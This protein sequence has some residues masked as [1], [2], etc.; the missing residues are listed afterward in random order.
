M[1]N[2]RWVCG[3]CNAD[4]EASGTGHKA[5]MDHAMESHPGVRGAIK[6][7]VDLETDEIVVPGSGPAVL[8]K[9]Q[10]LGYA[11]KKEE[12]DPARTDPTAPGA[13]PKPGKKTDPIRARAMYREVYIQPYTMMFFDIDRNA[14]AEGAPGGPWSDS[15]DGFT[16]WLHD[17]IDAWHTEHMP[18]LLGTQEPVAVAV[19][20]DDL[21]QLVELVGE[22]HTGAAYDVLRRLVDANA[23]TSRILQLRR[24]RVPNPPSPAE[25]A[26]S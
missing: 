5:A 10:R 22:G 18:E 6:G 4:F 8:R 3:V 12:S 14:L 11:A 19:P 23:V 17:I 15:D 21:H 13:Q 9:A 20:R 26:A 7:L 24:D 16:R 2:Y 1:P 25:V